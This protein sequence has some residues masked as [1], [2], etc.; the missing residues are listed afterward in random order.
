MMSTDAI[1]GGFSPAR[2]ARLTRG[3]EHYVERGEIA[4]LITLVYRR[5]R[6]AHSD[7]I[8]QRNEAEGLPMRRDSLFRIASMSKPIA[9]VAALMLLEEGKLR[10]GDPIHRWLPEFGR[11]K[12]LRDPLGALDDVYVSPRPIRVVDLLTHRAGFANGLFPEGPIG[13]AQRPLQSHMLLLSRELDAEGWLRHLG[14]LPLCYAPGE[15]V[16]YGYT[17]DVLGLLV[18][19]VSGVPFAEFLRTRIFDPLGMTDTAFF[20]P[21]EK[22]A[23]FSEGYT[24]D[25]RSLQRVVDDSAAASRWSAA[26]RLPS[27]AAGLVS[28]ADDY[29][30]F[31]RMLLAGGQLRG[32]RL[33]SRKTIELMTT[34]FLTPE[35]RKIDFFAA[36]DYWAGHGFGLGVGVVDNPAGEGMLTSIGQYGWGGAYGTHWFN[37]PREDMICILMLQLLGADL[38]SKIKFDFQN[39][40]YQAIDN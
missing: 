33:L 34:N 26:P 22:R 2:L 15:R 14:S 24:V 9:S 31:A 37:D 28:T 11:L 40:V 39:L 16:T 4:G 20:V 36:K 18:E 10:L 35:Q 5:G 13:E 19:R 17:T 38:Y 8:G 1:L 27:G 32:E 30:Q 6:L 3:M 21:E 25:P 7:V 29:L 12:V 23:R